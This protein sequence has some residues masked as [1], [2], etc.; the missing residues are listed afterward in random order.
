MIGRLSLKGA[1]TAVWA[2]VVADAGDVGARYCEDCQVAE[3]IDDPSSRMGVRAYALDPDN[4]KALW[5]TSEA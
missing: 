5:A 3:I 2:G 1:A 4:A